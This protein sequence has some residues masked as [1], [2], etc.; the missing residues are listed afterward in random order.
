MRA[1]VGLINPLAPAL[2]TNFGIDRRNYP[3]KLRLDHSL[4]VRCEIVVDRQI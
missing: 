2:L 1:K 3:T 4:L